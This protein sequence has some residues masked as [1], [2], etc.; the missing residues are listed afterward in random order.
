[1]AR[2]QLLRN[3]KFELEQACRDLDAEMKRKDELMVQVRNALSPF[4]ESLD[5]IS[6]AA[7]CQN[8]REAG[9][10]ARGRTNSSCG[11]L[12]GWCRAWT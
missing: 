9:G 6:S 1:M 11:C 7:H 4:P 5:L 3:G 12:G 2:L 8:L 10:E